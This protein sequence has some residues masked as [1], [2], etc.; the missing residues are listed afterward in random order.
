MEKI[1]IGLLFRNRREAIGWTQERTCEGICSVVTISRLEN[2]ERMPSERHIQALMERLGIVDIRHMVPQSPYEE[3]LEDMQAETRARV[4]RFTQAAPLDKPALRKEA[5]LHFQQLEAFVDK[6]DIMAQQRIAGDKLSL[7]KED[8]PYSMKEKVEL[9]IQALRLTIP[10]FDPKRIRDFRYTMEESKLVNQIAA[11][12]AQDGEWEPALSI[13][14]Q[15]FTYLRENAPRSPRYAAQR[16]MVAANYARE[17]AVCE[18]YEE[19]VAV[20]EEG[21]Q[22]CVQYGRYQHLPMLLALLANCHAHLNHRAESQKLYERA[23]CFYD[24]FNDKE[25]LAH[26]K[27]DAM[28]TLGFELSG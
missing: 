23:L 25:N 12:Y 7:G 26:L 14:R 6:S 17:L 15:L 16:A 2:G 1:P 8:G 4:I 10:G 11:A 28:D 3:K 20:A 13:Y 27:Q 19:A 9:L 21:R 22:V 18:R 5:L 24:E